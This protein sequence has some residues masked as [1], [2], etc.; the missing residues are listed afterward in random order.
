M[1]SF[2]HKMSKSDPNNAIL[3]HDDHDLLKKKIKKAFLEVGNPSSAIFEIV[4]HVILP[5]LGSVKVIPDPKYGVPSEYTD[6]HSFSSA[7]SEGTV[8]PLDAKMAVADALA[9]VLAPISEHFSSRTELMS[10]MNSITGS[11]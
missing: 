9:E 1:D 7:V 3:L 6:L 8:H 2:D 4:E 5:R 11:Q 10:A